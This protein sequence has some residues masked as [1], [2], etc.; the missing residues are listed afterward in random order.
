MTSTPTL[1]DPCRSASTPDRPEPTG[2][3]RPSSTRSIRARSPTAT[4]TA[5]ATSRASPSTSTTWPSSA[6][7]WSGCRRSTPRRWTTTAT[8]SATIKT[9]TR[10][11]A[12]WTT[13]T[14]L[15]AALHERGIKLVM[16]LVVNHTSDE[17]PWFVESRDPASAKRDW[18]WWRPA[19][20][21]ASSRA[22]RAPSRR[23]GR[24]PS[25]ARPGSS[26]RRS[27]E[28]YLHLFSPKQPDLNW[29]NP[30][31]RQAVYAMMRWWVD[32]GVD[33]FRMDVINLI[34]KPPRAGRRR[35]PPGSAYAPGDRRSSPT[36]RG[37]RS[38]WPR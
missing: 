14:Q 18:Y 15:I 24:R 32:R 6:S 2:G 12:R 37:W 34:S 23:T 4:A 13:W 17:H 35:V 16:D 19:R 26:T 21:P 27:G 38:S 22:P 36:G 31:V 9:S 3:S 7:T 33:G 29:E 20:A 25:P 28:Y 11:S 8:T 10:C 30:E 1:S 5:S